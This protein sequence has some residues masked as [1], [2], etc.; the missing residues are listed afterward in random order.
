MKFKVD[1][2]Y[3]VT[4]R[5][6]NEL[7]STPCDDGYDLKHIQLKDSATSFFLTKYNKVIFRHFYTNSKLTYIEES[8]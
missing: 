8:C 3:K 4:G 7:S 2:D 1:K 5:G 6:F